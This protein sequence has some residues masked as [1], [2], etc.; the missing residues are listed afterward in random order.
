MTVAVLGIGLMGR[1]IA[2]RLMACGHRVVVYNRTVEK[3]APLAALGAEVAPS[4]EAAIRAAQWVLLMLADAAAIHS[5]LSGRGVVAAL[6]GRVVIQMGTIASAESRALGQEIEGA[7]AEYL[8]APVLGSIAEAQDGRLLVMVGGRQELFDRSKELMLCLGAAPELVGPVGHAAALKLAL[9]QLIASHIAAFSL[10][11]GYLCRAGVSVD[12]FRKVLGQ[13]ALSA[14]MFEKKYPRLETHSYKDP[15]F[16]VRHLLK[17]VR[18]F[19]NEAEG[20]GLDVRGL[21]GV[22]LLLEKTITLDRGEED[23]S[24]VYEAINPGP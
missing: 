19:L 8:E 17:D 22:P 13:S 1:A 20:E 6:R 12:L 23:Y 4:P 16:T 11:L 14:P 21:S 10:S 9:N 2:G 18:L 7:G 15:N 3:C 24:A 5:V